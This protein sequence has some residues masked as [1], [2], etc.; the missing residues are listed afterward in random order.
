MGLLIKPE[1][2]VSYMLENTNTVLYTIVVSF[3]PVI[4]FVKVRELFPS[5]KVR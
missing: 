4:K 2:N 3:V 5:R 1:I